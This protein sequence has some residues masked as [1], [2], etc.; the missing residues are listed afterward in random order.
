[1]SY[2]SD[3]RTHCITPV[4]SD[5]L[6]S[7]GVFELWLLLSVAFVFPHS[8]DDSV[9]EVSFV[10]SSCFS[11]GFTFADLAVEVG[12]GLVEVP[13]LGDACDV[14]NAVDPSVPAEVETVPDWFAVA[15]T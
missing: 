12:S 15:F 8:A 1:M 5:A 9:G 11:F 3:R 7:S 10:G 14:E 4:M 2:L 13:L 6:L